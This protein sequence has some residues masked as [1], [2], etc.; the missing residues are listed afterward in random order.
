M[1][2]TYVSLALLISGL[3]PL[4]ALGALPELSSRLGPVVNLGYAAFAGNT[5][6]PTGELN[7]PVTF[8]GNIPYVQAPVGNLRFRAPQQLDES[9]VNSG[10][11]TI[12]DARN[13]GSA[14][15]Q[16]PAV[17]GAGSEDCLKLNIWKPS[18]AKQGDGLP[19]IF[20]THGG[21]FIYGTPHGFP[22]YDWVNQSAQKIVA[23]SIGYRLNLFGFLSGTEMLANGDSNAGLLDQ[24]AALEWVHRHIESFGGDPDQ[25]TID[26]QSAGGASVVMQTVAFGGS[27]PALFN[28]GIAQSIG[29][30]TATTEEAEAVFRNVARFVGCPTT[31]AEALS[32]LRGA[33]VGAIVAAVNQP[34]PGPMAPVVDGPTGILP[35]LPGALI[36]AGNFT[37]IDFV[38]GHCTNDGR[39]FVGGTPDEFVTDADIVQRVFAS[40]P[41]LTNMTIQKAL[42]M[43]PAP[44]TP[45]S[46]Y[47]TQYE[48]ASEIEQDIVF[49]C[50]DWYLATQLQKKG[51]QNLFTFRFNAPSPVLLSETPYEGVMH[52]SDLFFLFDGT[53]KTSNAGFI[54]T[55]FNETEAPLSQES[56][57]FWTSFISS[58][59]PSNFRKSFSPAWDPFS[60]GTRMVLTQDT[61]NGTSLT[62]SGM[63]VTPPSQIERC[64][65]WMSD[66]VTSQTGI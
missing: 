39:T 17:V 19:V 42:A 28:R 32:C 55:A 29:Y 52:T 50:M 16:Q 3:L 22:L 24:R 57:A 63:E 20:Y 14:C 61:T 44:G 64:M 23:V 21:G 33:S 43:Y 13:W 36:T 25:I 2:P 30:G 40:H 58:G 10:N 37:T 15:I 5:T 1:Y 31:R 54:F 46:P 65:F 47:A 45:G 48:R 66:N 26:G 18:D 12:T 60:S 35:A 51:V 11:V 62:S 7:G 53:N 59:D 4:L 34:Q 27:K 38:G 41:H 56:I 6:S 8:F 9:I 49:S